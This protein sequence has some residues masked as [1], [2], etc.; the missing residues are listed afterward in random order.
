MNDLSK[1]KYKSLPKNIKITYE[2]LDGKDNHSFV[3]VTWVTKMEKKFYL[4]RSSTAAN[5][6][7]FHFIKYYNQICEDERNEEGHDD[8]P[9]DETL[10]LV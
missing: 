9:E 8:E 1:G 10:L 5:N 6:E 7:L 3:H 2:M 4:H